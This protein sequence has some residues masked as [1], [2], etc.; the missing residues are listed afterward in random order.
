MVKVTLDGAYGIKAVTIDP[1]VVD[2]DD[3]A[4]LED[5]VTAAFRDA[6]AKL[7]EVQASADPMA[8]LDLGALG[9]LFGS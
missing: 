2:P 9:G 3:V 6:V 1:S 8:G 7:T 4:M 5:L